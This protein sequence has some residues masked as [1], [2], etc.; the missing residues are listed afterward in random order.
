MASWLLV[1]SEWLSLHFHASI[2]PGLWWIL[3]GNCQ[4]KTRSASWPPFD[5][6]PG[7]IS[8][9]SLGEDWQGCGIMPYHPGWKGHHYGRAGFLG[10]C[11]PVGSV[12]LWL[13][14]SWEKSHLGSQGWEA[15][16]VGSISWVHLSPMARL[17][18][19]TSQEGGM[20]GCS[21]PDTGWPSVQGKK[22]QHYH[23]HIN[24][25][26]YDRVSVCG[27]FYHYS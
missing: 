8:H 17:C 25:F 2:S 20:R 6:A 10:L 27:W 22:M 1:R 11:L 3:D 7:D 13:C 15:Q 23:D 9:L 14:Y 12:E 18:T 21:A 4:S 26:S 16:A 5:Q 24:K 19:E